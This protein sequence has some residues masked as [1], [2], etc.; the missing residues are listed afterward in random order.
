MR[1][2]AQQPCIVM[3]KRGDTAV[4]AELDATDR[5]AELSVVAAGDAEERRDTAAP[6]AN[7][8]SWSASSMW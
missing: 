8:T 3:R 5:D 2:A 7:S 6:S 4:V 1:A